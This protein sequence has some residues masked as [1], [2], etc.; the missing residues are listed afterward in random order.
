MG[1][2]VFVGLAPWGYVAA[3]IIPVV[4]AFFLPVALLLYR[5][6]WRQVLWGF[7]LVAVV[8]LIIASPVL[9]ELRQGQWDNY[10]ARSRVVSIFT[11]RPNDEAWR[12]V[13]G[14]V[15]DSLRGFVLLSN[16]DDIFRRSTEAVRYAPRG[17][18]LFDPVTRAL[19]FVGLI[20][21]LW[22]WR[23][24]ALWWFMFLPL[25]S[26]QVFSGGTPDAARGLV[27]LPA[28]FLFV[29]L[30][31][32]TVLRWATT[33]S[34]RWRG[35]TSAVLAALLIVAASVS[36]LSVRS[37]FNWMESDY[38]LRDRG[39]SVSSEEFEEWSFYMRGVAAGEF[40]LNPGLWRERQDRAGCLTATVAGTSVHIFRST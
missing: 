10:T 5:D 25:L 8:S 33:T 16:D 32:H 14:Q 24:T 29:A 12:M 35:A 11:G 15:R 37:Y 18:N 2:G 30:G 9:N 23:Q 6:R 13:P 40:S 19:F 20:A 3:R 31:L 22:R 34:A 21:S 28:I 4:V 39:P 36:A 27:A 7:G 1:A 26:I 17:D 38:A